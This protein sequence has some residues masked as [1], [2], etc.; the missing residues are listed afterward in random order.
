[1]QVRGQLQKPDPVAVPSSNAMSLG[2]FGEVSVSK[3]S[4]IPNVNIP[5]RVVKEH[6]LG[7][8]ISLSYYGGGVL[9]DVHP[10]WVGLGWSLNA[11]GIITRK[12]NGKEDE[13]PGDL[14]GFF[15]GHYLLNDTGWSSQAR[16]LSFDQAS[17]GG[18]E[19]S[20]DEFSFSVNGISG[21]FYMNHTGN[22][23]I[24][25]DQDVKIIFDTSDFIF[26]RKNFLSSDTSVNSFRSFYKFTLIA[27]DGTQYIFGGI[28]NAIEYSINFFN[29]ND[30]HWIAT[31][32]YLTKI[33][34][35]DKSHS[36]A[37]N[38]ERDQYTN[39]LYFNSF[40]NDYIWKKACK[41]RTQYA[42]SI[43]SGSL[44][45]PIYLSSIETKN[46]KVVFERSTTTELRYSGQLYSATY[47]MYVQ[48]RVN[49][50]RSNN[51]SIHK[52]SEDSAKVDFLPL[53]QLNGLNSYPSMLHN[54]QWKK[55]DSIKVIDKTNANKVVQRFGFAYNNLHY[56]RLK[57]K[58][59]GEVSLSGN[60]ISPPHHF[61]YND[62]IPLPLYL[63]QD[64]DDWDGYRGPGS[65]GTGF[66]NREVH[67]DYSTTGM[68]NQIMYPTGG[69]S[70]FFFEP[71]DYSIKVNEN[72]TS[73]LSYLGVN[74]LA[75]G[76]RVKAIYSY[77]PV[78]GKLFGKRYYYVNNYSNA[79]GVT[80]KLSSGILASVPKYNFEDSSYIDVASN[81][82]L[83]TR[84]R[85]F[86]TILPLTNNAMGSKVGYSEVTEQADD[87]SYTVY[88]YTNFNDGHMDEGYINAIYPA[89]AFMNPFTS[90]ELER[91]YLKFTGAFTKGD[92]CLSRS[93]TEYA[94]IHNNKSFVRSVYSTRAILCEYGKYGVTDQ[95]GPVVYEGVSY[96][97]Y[98]YSYVPVS[99]ADTLYDEKGQ[100][101][102]VTLINYF[103]DN[104][105]TKLLTRTETFRTD[106]NKVSNLLVYPPDYASGNAFI[107]SMV[108]KNM[109]STPV[110]SVEYLTNPVS[111]VV[112]ILS[113]K[114][115][116][117]KP[118][119]VT[120]KA[121]DL[122]L[123]S[124][125]PVL[126]DSFKF[127]NRLKGQ[128]AYAG[129]PSAY[130]A[131]SRYVTK[132]VYDSYDSAGNLVQYTLPD[133]G[134]GGIIWGYNKSVP[135]AEVTNAAI[136]NA[137][138]NGF[139]EDVTGISTD[140]KVG[141]KSKL[142]N[143]A[144][145]AIP[146]LAALSGKKYL[147]S[148]WYKNSGDLTWKFFSSTYATLPASVSGHVVIDELRIIPE[149]AAIKSYSYISPLSGMI[150]VNDD[151]NNIVKYEYDE[152]NRLKVVRDENND[153]IKTIEYSYSSDTSNSTKFYFNRVK[154]SVFT[155]NNCTGGKT[156]GQLIYSVAAG[157]YISSVSQSQADS[158]ALADIAL[159]GQNYANANGSCLY[160][161]VQKSGTYYRQGCA[162]ASYNP[163]PPYLYIVP[164][165]T[166]TSA[167]SQAQADS[168]AQTDVNSYGQI[169]ANSDGACPPENAIVYLTNNAP[170]TPY[171]VSIL[172]TN[173][174]TGLTYSLGP[175]TSPTTV[176]SVSR[177][178]PIGVYNISFS[179]SYVCS[180]MQVSVSGSANVNCKSCASLGSGFTNIT[181]NNTTTVTMNYTGNCPPPQ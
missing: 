49:G 20:P 178:V 111:G 150:G 91:G 115:A 177:T 36:I 89:K 114:I 84:L 59:F 119:N 159:N 19:G 39:I 1:M 132:M 142:L 162:F 25:C 61:F 173:T 148:Y 76:V 41:E 73:P 71:N 147:L 101:P 69:Y 110:E 24:K 121:A 58:S 120:Q 50:T 157:T 143:G 35:P 158:L 7:T 122:A 66:E 153:V 53:L 93:T 96:K 98:T 64:V 75:G 163:V 78:A 169:K 67:P 116:T 164:A 175:V 103:Y 180:N 43:I 22:W 60:T 44:I 56:E 161:N 95:F 4:G 146:S 62:S 83:T 42:Q 100:N 23:Q 135:L 128:L 46:E 2:V 140:N 52:I 113:G 112:K 33:I 156:G 170:G 77:D 167:F 14:G 70:L 30:D 105:N 16:I 133:Q 99:R 172:L 117:Y 12:V 166:Y 97:I 47:Q 108:S 5:I 124:F 102:H 79:T 15:D 72:R 29:Q 141:K 55:L 87:G 138:Y 21:S 32:W 17:F 45:S 136:V 18:F 8:D 126:L 31:S 107:D 123:E 63:S 13:L 176:Q 86:K 51:P 145:F 6:D 179:G 174:V 3:F 154:S 125:T 81:D 155:K 82:T 149:D 9:P 92:T 74:K 40:M 65:G 152:I 88:K 28:R 48:K 139:E 90:L 54:I 181:I 109:I 106:G 34:A 104:P 171:S 144:S 38:Y 118:S 130:Q 94:P 85:S 26:P 37:F 10:G 165:G 127:S 129:S 160:Y 27:N 134:S 11:G 131:D 168:A 80:G 137:Y 57:L 68:L 151:A